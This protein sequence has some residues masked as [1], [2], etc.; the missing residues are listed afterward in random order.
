YR[1]GDWV[2][3]PSKSRQKIE[4][5]RVA[6]ITLQQDQRGNVTGSVVLHDRLLERSV[7]LQKQ[8]T[9]VSGGA[10]VGTGGSGSKPAPK[11]RK[12]ARPGGSTTRPTVTGAAYTDKSGTPRAV[13]T[14]VWPPVNSGVDGQAIDIDHYEVRLRKR[15]D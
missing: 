4:R 2:F 13:I 11:G 8:L 1:P 10:T 15:K 3:G 12:P 6:Q 14:I 5:L 7:A 9:A